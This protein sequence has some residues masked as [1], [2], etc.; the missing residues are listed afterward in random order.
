L[1]SFYDFNPSKIAKTYHLYPIFFKSILIS[2]INL[3][4]YFGFSSGLPPHFLFIFVKFTTS[5]SLQFIQIPLIP[6]PPNS[7]PHPVHP[8]I[9]FVSAAP[10]NHPSHPSTQF[11]ADLANPCCQP[12]PKP[13]KYFEAPILS[14]QSFYRIS[15]ITIPYPQF[16]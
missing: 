8:Q 15:P 1:I 7:S 11:S 12:V 10:I 3:I 5:Y 9:S 6:I 14:I 2:W 4:F 13:A 16:S